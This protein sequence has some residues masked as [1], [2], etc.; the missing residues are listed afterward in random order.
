MNQAKPKLWT[1]DFVI[2]SAANFFVALTFSY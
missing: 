1:K 2:I